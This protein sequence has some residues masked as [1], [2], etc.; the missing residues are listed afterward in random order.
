MDLP[1]RL[2]RDRLLEL[3]ATLQKAVNETY[4]PSP[5]RRKPRPSDRQARNNERRYSLQHYLGTLHRAIDSF[6][7]FLRS[8]A[9]VAA[10][11]GA[12]MLT[13]E[14]G[15]GKTH[16]FCDAAKRATDAGRPGIVLLAGR[17]SGRRV[18]REIADQLGLGEAGREAVIGAMKAAAQASNAPFLLLIDALNEA[19]DPKAWREE[20]PALLAEVVQSPWIVLGVSIRSTFRSIVLPSGGLSGVAEVEHRGF[21]RR[22]LEAT[23]RFFDAFGLDQPRIPL[24]TPEFTNPLFLKLYCEGLQE[25]GHRAPST[26]QKPR[27]RRLRTVPHVEGHT[28]RVAPGS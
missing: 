4:P 20:L 17:M 21:E 24:L 2:G 25:I 11:C 15:Q 7:A 8:G 19:E 13:G 18:W 23:E 10:E 12:L 9:C 1:V 6:E 27:Q 28:N 14:A 16:L 26:R 5:P 3:S 22:E